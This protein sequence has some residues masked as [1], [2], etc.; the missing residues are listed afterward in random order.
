MAP[1]GEVLVAGERWTARLVEGQI[2]EVGEPV[3]VAGMQDIC[4]LVEA[5]RGRE[6]PKESAE[7]LDET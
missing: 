4:L 6:L 2:A 3:R 7:M 5:L 1:E